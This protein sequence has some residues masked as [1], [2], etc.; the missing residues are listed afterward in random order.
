MGEM[1]ANGSTG[2]DRGLRILFSA[3]GVLVGLRGC[4]LVLQVL[5][6]LL[7]TRLLAIEAVGVYAV[8]NTGWFIVKG[9]GSLGLGQAS[10]RFI[11][12]F[13]AQEQKGF[14]AQLEKSARGLV[15]TIGAATALVTLAVGLSAKGLGVVDLHASVLVAAALGVPAYAL[16]LLLS[17]QLRARQFVFWSLFPEAVILPSVQA[18]ALG[19][20]WYL[21]VVTLDAVLL[22]QVL[23]VWI[24]L[25]AYFV[26][27]R[28][29]GLGTPVPLPA[30][31]WRKIRQ[32]AQKIFLTSL[33]TLIAGRS[34][35]FIV[36][37]ILGAPAAAI[38]ETANRFGQLPMLATWAVGAGISPMLSAAHGHG[39]RGKLQDLFT[40]GSWLAFAPVMVYLAFLTIFGPWLLASLFGA[41]YTEAYVP[42]L[43][44]CTATVITASAGMATYLYF[45]T[46]YE[47]T[48][49]V[50]SL[51]KLVVQV[52]AAIGLGLLYGVSG[53][54][55][56]MLIGSIVRDIGMSTL[57]GRH[58][59][60]H[61]GVWSWAGVRSVGRIFRQ[62]R[63]G[64][65]PSLAK[66]D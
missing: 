30:S 54:A 48:A 19:V 7:I 38:M 3:A 9:L 17:S 27:D 59:N 49:F 42:M 23:A 45:M 47:Q 29:N 53:V 39:D 50:F 55:A 22:A 35:L 13:L 25:A 26:A 63:Q 43:L 61:A 10:L 28:V 64:P 14:A 60:M 16:L 40:F 21:D 31:E 18:L 57:L 5:V 56:A 11:P 12:H 66:P 24:V 20:V 51:A 8:V 65:S 44:V 6:F 33:V 34:P 1:S 58:L 41:D 36:S 15:T 62:F 32:V 4:G 52:G 2:D 37:A 46:G